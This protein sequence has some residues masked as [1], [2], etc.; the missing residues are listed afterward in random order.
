MLTVTPMQHM[1]VKIALPLRACAV[2]VRRAPVGTKRLAA[3]GV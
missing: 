1:T 2:A 3:S